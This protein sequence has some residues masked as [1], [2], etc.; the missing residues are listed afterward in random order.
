MEILHY[1]DVVLRQ[2][3]GKLCF[4]KRKDKVFLS[5]NRVV[6]E[7][8]VWIFRV[9]PF[10]IKKVVEF[11]SKLPPFMSYFAVF[12]SHLPRFTSYLPIF[13]SYLPPFLTNLP[14]SRPTSPL[15]YRTSLP[16]W[17]CNAFVTLA[18]FVTSSATRTLA[19]TSRTHRVLNSCL[20][21]HLHL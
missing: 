6:L 15:S 5:D 4:I 19:H 10:L 9:L 17:E 21:L 11:L 1:V 14:V 13:A 18:H 2:E 20:H 3:R 12:T 16:Y 8:K 7:E